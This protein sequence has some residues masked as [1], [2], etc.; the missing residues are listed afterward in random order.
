M[1][2]GKAI[3]TS[4]ISVSWTPL[5]KGARH[6]LVLKKVAEDLLMSYV[7]CRTYRV[8]DMVR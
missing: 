3:L 6:I 7:T 8:P 2:F 1:K 4:R 5:G